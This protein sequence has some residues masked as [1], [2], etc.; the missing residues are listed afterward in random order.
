MRVRTSQITP[1]IAPVALLAALIYSQLGWRK[2]LEVAG[3]LSDQYRTIRA[4]RTF[5]SDGEDLAVSAMRV[6]RG[7]DTVP[8]AEIVRGRRAVIYFGRPNCASCTWFEAEM[9]SIMP[10]WRDS[11]VVVTSYGSAR[12]PVSGLTLDSTSSLAI[13]GVPALLV[14]DSTGYVRHSVPAGVPQVAHVLS[15]V[16]EPSPVGRLT[17]GYTSTHPKTALARQRPEQRSRGY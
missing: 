8:L 17:A 13:T 4:Q 1:L 10:S 12:G 2:T 15:F 5:P 14:V 3:S 9:D 16:G 7:K 6:I 11:L